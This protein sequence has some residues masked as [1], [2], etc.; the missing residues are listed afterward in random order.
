MIQ[1]FLL[2]LEQS[3]DIKAKDADGDAPLHEAS[4]HGQDTIVS[5]L[6]ENG[7]TSM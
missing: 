2:L 3:A 5:L 4:L 1:P 7:P 6:L